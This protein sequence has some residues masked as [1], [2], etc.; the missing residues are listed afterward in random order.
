MI[1]ELSVGEWRLRALKHEDAAPWLAIVLDP[2]LRRLTSWSIEDLERM[3]TI[4]TDYVEGPR[5]ETTRRWAIVD[6][7]GVFSGTCGFKDW[8]RAKNTAEL[9]YELAAEHRGKNVMSAIAAAVVAH[10][11]EEMGLETIRAL[12]NVENAAS[13]RL[14]AKLG[15][16]RTE[17]LKKFR[18]CGGELK[19]FSAYALSR[20]R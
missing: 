13:H 3:Q 6:A 17:I 10:G 8:D 16:Q 18:A 20:V 11:L 1:P 5:A 4:V 2:G 7:R 12:V 9:S 15:F 19:D 14:L